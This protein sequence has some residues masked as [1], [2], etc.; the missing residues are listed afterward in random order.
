[1]SNDDLVQSPLES[2]ISSCIVP[3]WIQA[4]E[5]RK[6][7]SNNNNNNNSDYNE[8]NTEEIIK[9]ADMNGVF[10]NGQVTSK[11]IPSVNKVLSTPI[12]DK[13]LAP[14]ISGVAVGVI[15]K[16]IDVP[17]QN[18]KSSNDINKEKK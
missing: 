11:I 15:L 3:P 14:I 1:M 6:L 17:P 12:G 7:I 18:T 8:S 10:I 9:R 5:I 13:I 16:S 2:N 4:A